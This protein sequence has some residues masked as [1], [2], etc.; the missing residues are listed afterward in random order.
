MKASFVVIDFETGGTSLPDQRTEE[1]LVANDLARICGTYYDPP[2]QF[3]AIAY[4]KEFVEVESLNILISFDPL[5]CSAEALEICH[6]DEELWKK[7]AIV[8][9]MA[10]VRICK[11]FEKHAIRMQHDK[12]PFRAARL[13]AHNA[14]FDIAHLRKLCHWKW[15]DAAF[16]HGRDTGYM[17]T[18][19]LA[20]WYGI[21]RGRQF[22]SL[23]LEDIY[24]E[25]FNE[26]YN[27]HD[28]LADCRATAR[29]A[30]VMMFGMRQAWSFARDVD[31][32]TDGKPAFPGQE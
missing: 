2:V 10:S 18:K 23:K 17:D 16:W 14:E 24:V 4:T 31:A 7:S 20:Q 21:M 6:Y 8:A 26:P 12:G 3:A 13:M 28:A 30:R 32:Y 25:L 9:P 15:C 11:F 5:L 27:A 22:K 1:I 29:I 19:H